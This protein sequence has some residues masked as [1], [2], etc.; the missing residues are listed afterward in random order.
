ML[1]APVRK[2][3]ATNRLAEMIG[4]PGGSTV[5]DALAGAEAAI[6]R[7]RPEVVKDIDARIGELEDL[8]AQTTPDPK[9]LYRTAAG[10]IEHAGLFG[11]GDLGK[12]AYSLCELV[13][14]LEQRGVWDTAS[15]EVH[16]GA[17]H[18]L[19]NLP[20]NDGG[21]RARLLNGLNAV[22]AKAA[23]ARRNARAD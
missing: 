9:S 21:Q 6:E 17:M 1:A 4:L 14:R 18:L 10:I 19:R 3:A 12:A 8:A 16:I 23:P 15:V 13:D 7:Y 11:M 20:E 5:G 2:F 22:T